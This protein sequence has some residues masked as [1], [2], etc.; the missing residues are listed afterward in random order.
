LENLIK[1]SAE[2][3]SCD[4]HYLTIIDRYIL[5]TLLNWLKPPKLDYNETGYLKG[6]NNW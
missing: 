1:D 3:I 6:G 4:V 5:A 2:C